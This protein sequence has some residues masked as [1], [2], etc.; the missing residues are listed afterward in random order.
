MS[1]YQQLIDAAAQAATHVKTDFIEQYRAQI[2]STARCL[3]NC[4][5]SGH[6]VLIFGNGGSAADAQHIA[7]EFINRFLIERRPIPA[8]A[9]TTDTSI[10]TAI[11]NDYAFD[12]IFVKQIQALGEAD[13]IAIGIST[14]G[15]STN[16]LKGIRVAAQKGLTTIG[17]SGAKGALGDLVDMAFKVPSEH[18]PRIQEIHLFLAHLLCELME[19][20][21]F[22]PQPESDPA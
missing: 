3:A 4:I 14:S 7:A 9:L 1:S 8:M 13:D 5:A 2:V 12:Q 16:V 18:T 17:I 19:I 10:I 15:N 21:L 22:N 11:A 6:K 20:M